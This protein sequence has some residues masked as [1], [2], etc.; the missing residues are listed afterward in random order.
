[1]A[2]DAAAAMAH[3]HG[4]APLILGDAIEGESR[5][6][7][8]VLAGIACSVRERGHPPP[9]LMLLSGGETVVTMTSPSDAAR[10][11]R[12]TELLSF[13]LANAGRDEVW[14]FACDTD[15]IDGSG[16]SAGR[17]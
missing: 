3:R 17:W 8:I 16:D 11:S 1:M 14:A 12:N 2:L 10:G 4:V 7:R 9:P 15:G 5:E 13:A 6:L